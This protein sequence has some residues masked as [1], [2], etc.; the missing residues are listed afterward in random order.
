[1]KRNYEN[2]FG[3]EDASW[4]E[5][6]AAGIRSE[7]QDLYTE[8]RKEFVVLRESHRALNAVLASNRSGSE[9]EEEV[10]Q[11]ALENAYRS[12]RWIESGRV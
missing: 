7:R 9:H 2:R 5:S 10:V 1:M 8:L 11:K 12:L 6:S 3:I 4:L